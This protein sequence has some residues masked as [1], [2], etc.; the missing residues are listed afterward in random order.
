MSQDASDAIFN[1]NVLPL[2]RLEN[3]KIVAPIGCLYSPMK[4]YAHSSG[5]LKCGSCDSYLNPYIKAIATL[6]WCPFCDKTNTYS[7]AVDMSSISGNSVE[8]TLPTDITVTNTYSINHVLL[9]DLYDNVDDFHK[10]QEALLNSIS[11]LPSTHYLT[12]ISYSN[13]VNLHT[14]DET[15]KFSTPEFADPFNKS[16]IDILISRAGEISF[17]MTNENK[18]K[19][20]SIISSL[21]KVKTDT[22]RAPRSTGLAL[23]ISIILSTSLKSTFLNI[24]LFTSGPATL[25]PGNIVDAGTSVRS[26]RNLKDSN[27]F[28]AATKFYSTLAYIACGLKI[29]QA[30]NIASGANRLTDFNIGHGS[31]CS[32]DIFVAS[33]EQVGLREMHSLIDLTMGNAYMYENWSL[34]TLTV[35]INKG[36]EASTICHTL[37]VLTSNSLKISNLSG[38]GCPLASSYTQNESRYAEHN[39]RISDSITEYDSTYNKSFTNRWRFPKLRDSTCLALYFDVETV[40]TSL[41]N[42]RKDTY[43]QFQVKY[44]DLNTNSWKVKVSTTRKRAT[45]SFAF[46]KGKIGDGLRETEML[47]GLDQTAWVVLFSKLMVRKCFTSDVDAADI[48][49]L[50]DN[51]LIRILH[52]FK[53]FSFKITDIRTYS[54]NLYSKLNIRYR[55]HEQVR[56]LVS[57]LYNLRRN[58]HLIQ[59]FN[60]SPD[61]ST[62][63]YSWFTNLDSDNS[64]TIIEPRLFKYCESKLI[65]ISLD[66]KHL[67][68]SDGSWLIFD[69][70]FS[71]ILYYLVPN[72][73]KKLKLHPSNNDHLLESIQLKDPVDLALKLTSTRRFDSKIIFT[74]T[75]HSQSRYLISYLYPVEIEDDTKKSNN[76]LNIFKRRVDKLSDE[77]SLDDYYK[78]IFNRVKTYY[79]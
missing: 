42:M 7:E 36:L 68:D 53:E 73:S 75:N 32:I 11:T 58:H 49:K 45:S 28:T 52:L 54:L 5:L 10:L 41:V 3:S 66:S 13:T 16:T 78:T 61:E 44:F 29:S 19:L 69:T 14:I 62:F 65:N 67:L 71:I 74:Q 24:K 23:Y 1:W 55:V 38:G 35:S 12:L 63:Y 37:T 51:S 2:T 31:S 26:H 15:I 70:F 18:S 47:N 48:I 17:Q 22:S 39:E 72:E 9:I 50:I 34:N 8:F 4:Q 60:I 21:P 43:V 20:S 40:K 57:S 25:S 56:I 33:V 27:T 46:P 64:L 30:V 59:L 79:P 77:I 76:F 6:Y